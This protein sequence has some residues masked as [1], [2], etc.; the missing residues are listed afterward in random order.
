M[1]KKMA[2]L[3]GT[4]LVSSSIT[5]FAGLELVDYSTTVGKLNGKGYTAYQTKSTTGAAAD[6]YTDIVGG[7]YEVDVRQQD[8]NGSTGDWARNFGDYTYQA[9]DGSAS[10]LAKD[11]VRAQLSNDLTT[12]VNVQVS[13][14]WKSF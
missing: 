12:P 9:L 7:D 10:Q 6:F 4:I 13:G 14:M 3:L 1:K 2:I 8:A 5:A 11:S